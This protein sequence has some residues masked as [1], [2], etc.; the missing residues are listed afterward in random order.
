MNRRK[1]GSL[2][3]IPTTYTQLPLPHSN[4]IPVPTKPISTEQFEPS[5]LETMKTEEAGVSMYEPS[6][7]TVPFNVITLT[8]RNL[9]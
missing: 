7:V 9:V 2:K 1:N 5:A 8:S 4:A 6:N 3:Y